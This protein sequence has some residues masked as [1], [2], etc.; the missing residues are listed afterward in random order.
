MDC[1]QPGRVCLFPS[2]SNDGRSG[3]VRDRLESGHLDFEYDGVETS[4]DEV[5]EAN[6]RQAERDEAYEDLERLMTGAKRL[7]VR[8]F[9]VLRVPEGGEEDAA[10]RLAQL[11]ASTSQ[12]PTTS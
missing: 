9:S 4:F 11:W 8:D 2:P 1:Y 12:A 10:H 3:V 5:L 7:P 6:L